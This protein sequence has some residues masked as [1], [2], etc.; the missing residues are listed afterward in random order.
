MI[1]RL[2]FD[3]PV[4]DETYIELV[5]SLA[6]TLVNTA[7]FGVL[8]S[9]VAVWAMANTTDLALVASG[10]AGVILALA[11]V[12]AVLDLRRRVAGPRPTSD[13]ARRD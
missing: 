9:I 11:R 5:R 13:E 3:R 10:I 8:F 1:M 2:A 6:A 7:L 12:A 4:D